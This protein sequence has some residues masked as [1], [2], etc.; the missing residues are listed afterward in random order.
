MKLQPGLTV[1]RAYSYRVDPS[2]PPFPDDRPIIVFDGHCVL[3]S[4]FAQFVLRHDRQATFRLVA[5]QSPLGQALYRHWQLDAVNFKT[6]LLV[7]EGRA[8]V[9]SAGTIR[10][11]VKLGWPWALVA[12]LRLVPRALLDRVYELVAR[13]RLRWFGAR[14]VCFAP[15]P[16]Q[17]DRFLG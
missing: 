16:S 15:D 6:N 5:A 1:D 7:D 13:N 12:V 17:R 3:C 14:A 4:G 8:W 2:V 11:F 10:M 9:K